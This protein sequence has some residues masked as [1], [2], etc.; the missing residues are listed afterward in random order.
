[1][2][3]PDRSPNANFMSGLC[4]LGFFCIWDYETL[5]MEKVRF[6]G[7]A[8]LI[9]GEFRRHSPEFHQWRIEDRL[10]KIEADPDDVRL[11]DDL[12]VS[13]EKTG[14]TDLAIQTMLD[15]NKIK[16]NL[17]ETHA[18]LGTFYIHAGEFE[19]GLVEIEKAIELN[20]KAHFGREV[21]Q[22]YLVEYLIETRKVHGELP[23][24]INEEA[25]SNDYYPTGFAG[26]VVSKELP[27]AFKD[28]KFDYEKTERAQKVMAPAIKGV[29]GMM[30]FGNYDSPILLESFAHL[31]LFQ[32]DEPKQLAA[33][34]LLKASYEVAEEEAKRKYRTMA[35]RVIEMQSGTELAD[36]E[37]ELKKEIA[38]G[39]KWFAGIVKNEKAW[40]ESGADVEAEYAKV[41]YQEPSDVN[42]MAAIRN[43]RLMA[44]ARFA[45]WM[46]LGFAVFG[47]WVFVKKRRAT[48]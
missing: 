36:L 47:V 25:R 3:S 45:G 19:K 24:P 6:P 21:Y 48:A 14:Q 33:R 26:F 27:E 42:R 44:L 40:I 23:L 1:M 12:S 39:E 10:K 30:R 46:M 34:A 17:Y 31:V 20:P 8:E 15:K 32:E 28:G 5:F 41:Y 16:P 43:H 18:N 29:L 22:K 37:G 4:L 13:Y 9:A 2:F 7:A 38:E 11:L 35:Q